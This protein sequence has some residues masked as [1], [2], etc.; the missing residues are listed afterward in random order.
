MID[1]GR[2]EGALE[3]TQRTLIHGV[4]EM[5]DRPVS[6]LMVPRVDIFCLPSSMRIEEMKREVIRA[7]HSRIP[8]YGRD[9]DDIRG[10]LLAADLL[11]IPEGVEKAFTIESYLRKV[12][13]VP[14]CKTA[15]RL[16]RHFRSGACKPLWWRTNTAVCPGFHPEDI[17]EQLFR[18]VYDEH[19]GI[20]KDLGRRWGRMS[21]L[22]RAVWR[23]R[24]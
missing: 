7:R 19:G 17:L 9:R 3:E 4:F 2:Q 10:L 13:F 15:G 21:G 14:E 1:A 20:R 22:S 18:D 12:Y 6:E 16:L 5:E 11:K 8:I 24:T 23:R